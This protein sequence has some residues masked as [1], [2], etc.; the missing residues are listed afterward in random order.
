[1]DDV[2]WWRKRQEHL[3]RAER[4]RKARVRES[5]F[6][7]KEGVSSLVAAVMWLHPSGRPS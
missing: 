6:A 4:A 7:A 2:E 5:N 1:M 3:A